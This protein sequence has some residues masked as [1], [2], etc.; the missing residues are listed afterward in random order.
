MR[1]DSSG[2]CSSDRVV[3][4]LGVAS[5]HNQVLATISRVKVHLVDLLA[6]NR[7]CQKRELLMMRVVPW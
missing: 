5:L 1:I 7:C 6:L 2:A 3:L 4:L